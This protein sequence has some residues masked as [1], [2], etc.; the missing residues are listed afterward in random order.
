MW[1]NY[2]KSNK[3]P[4]TDWGKLLLVSIGISLFLII[5]IIEIIKGNL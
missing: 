5:L 3:S 4:L 1:N 2:K